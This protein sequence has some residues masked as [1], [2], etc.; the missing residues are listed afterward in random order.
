MFECVI[1]VPVTPWAI[2]TAREPSVPPPSLLMQSFVIVTF[3]AETV[4]S[5][6][7]SMFWIVSPAVPASMFPD[8]VSDEHATDGPTFPYLGSG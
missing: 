3:F 8:G 4:T 6:E 2:V 5:P 1:C 7:M